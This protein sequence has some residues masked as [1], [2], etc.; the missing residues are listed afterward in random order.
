DNKRLIALRDGIFDNRNGDG[1]D[2][3]E[4]GLKDEGAADVGVIQASGGSA[5]EGRVLDG[6][7]ISSEAACANDVDRDIGPAFI[8]GVGWRVKAE[9]VLVIDDGQDRG[10][11][12]KAVGRI[13]QMQNDRFIAFANIVVNDVDVEGLVGLAIG[14]IQHHGVKLIIASG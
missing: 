7:Q 2:K 1:F 9:G 3:V 13:G 11:Q 4:E 14:K 6:D 12:G 10:V 5:V 8:H